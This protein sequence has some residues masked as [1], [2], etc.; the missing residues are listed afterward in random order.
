MVDE[1]LGLGGVVGGHD[2]GEDELV[3]LDLLA[4]VHDLGGTRKCALHGSSH[5]NPGLKW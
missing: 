3:L 5:P 4:L 2:G 1:L